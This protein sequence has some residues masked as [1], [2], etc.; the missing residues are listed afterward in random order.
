MSL[1]PSPIGME[2]PISIL[3]VGGEE[4]LRQEGLTKHKRRDEVVTE[5]V[6]TGQQ[7][8]EER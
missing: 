4:G 2:S 6:E 5:C 7:E 1:E 3:T 8:K